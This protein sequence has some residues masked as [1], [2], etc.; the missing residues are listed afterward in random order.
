MFF[1]KIYFSSADYFTDFF[2]FSR[3]IPLSEPPQG[4][5]IV[6][7]R[8]P[9]LI[10]IGPAG[11]GLPAHFIA[12]CLPKITSEKLKSFQAKNLFL[13]DKLAVF[14]LRDSFKDSHL[15]IGYFERIISILNLS[16]SN[17][18]PRNGRVFAA[19]LG[20]RPVQCYCGL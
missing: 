18:I 5:L 7:T 4:V 8:T 14:T 20:R 1:L 3:D 2:D 12:Q 17:T 19:A 11:E 15:L 13:E 10:D 16:F 6:N 9:S